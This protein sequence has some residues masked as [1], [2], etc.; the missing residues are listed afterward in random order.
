MS[1][2]LLKYKPL[3]ILVSGLTVMTVMTVVT[4]ATGV[5]V[6]RLRKE[7]VVKKSCE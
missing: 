7:K 6:E 4:V 5:T 1:H 3:Y 2:S